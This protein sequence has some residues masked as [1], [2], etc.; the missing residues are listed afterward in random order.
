M[1]ASEKIQDE[2]LVAVRKHY[3]MVKVNGRV[4]FRAGPSLKRFGVS[5]I[6]RGCT[7]IVFDM[8]GCLGMDST[9]MGVLAGLA[10]R[11]RR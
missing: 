10:F 5:A 6:E 9:F 11:V 8:E 3:A 1:E 2:L 4:S 7:Q